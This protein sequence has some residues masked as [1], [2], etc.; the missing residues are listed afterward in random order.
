MLGSLL[1]TRGVCRSRFPNY[2][3]HTRTEIDPTN[4]YL[5]FLAY[6]PIDGFPIGSTLI[7]TDIDPQKI[8]TSKDAKAEPTGML[9]VLS[10]AAMRFN[11]DTRKYSFYRR[12]E[13]NIWEYYT[14]NSYEV[15]IAKI[16]D[17]IFPD[18]LLAAIIYNTLQAAI[19]PD[20]EH[21]FRPSASSTNA[22]P[23]Q[24]KPLVILF[25]AL[26][27][28][29]FGNNPV[30][31]ATTFYGIL[32]LPEFRAANICVRFILRPQ[33]HAV[34]SAFK[35]REFPEYYQRNDEPQVIEVTRDIITRGQT[36]IQNFVKMHSNL[37]EKS[38]QEIKSERDLSYRLRAIFPIPDDPNLG[39]QLQVD[40]TSNIAILTFRDDEKSKNK[41]AL[42][43]FAKRYQIQPLDLEI[44]EEGVVVHIHNGDANDTLTTRIS[45]QT[46]NAYLAVVEPTADE[47]FREW[48]I[49]FA[50]EPSVT[51]RMQ[52]IPTD[53]PKVYKKSYRFTERYFWE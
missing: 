34:V 23:Y 4:P 1:S 40:T 36:A 25:P 2:T 21:L 52:K 48:Q 28:G 50:N 24:S 14:H 27:T 18:P 51:G 17:N 39:F 15:P 20:N 5:T 43:S 49:R 22:N 46:L 45:V 12:L 41:T 7:S 31:L 32:T 16:G 35:E 8:D 13:N 3:D 47:L 19:S 6:D 10:C 53:L 11:N 9:S 30:I 44:K 29:A 42:E 33:D 38:D 26:G 37:R